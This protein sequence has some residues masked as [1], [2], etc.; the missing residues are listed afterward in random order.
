MIFI[1]DRTDAVSSFVM[2]SQTSENMF[3]PIGQHNIGVR[4]LCGCKYNGPKNNEHIPSANCALISEVRLH[5]E[6][7][8]VQLKA[9][10]NEAVHVPTGAPSSAANTE[11]RA[12]QTR[13]KLR[14]TTRKQ[15][16]AI[17]TLTP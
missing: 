14:L 13:A 1:V 16:G 12:E 9:P 11:A 6:R 2:R 8:E 4:I 3:V 10:Q 17:I 15:I 7:R 5:V